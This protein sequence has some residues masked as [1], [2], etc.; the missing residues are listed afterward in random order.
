MVIEGR[1]S[2]LNAAFA[3][4]ADP[5]R[6]A[7]IARL[8]IGAADVSELMKPFQLSQ[9]AI[10]KHL[11]VLEK[12]GLVERGRDAQRRPRKLVAGPLK[13]VAAW[14]EPYRQFWQQRLASL[15]GFLKDQKR[16]ENQH[17]ASK[18]QGKRDHDK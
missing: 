18:G 9:P 13:D 17:S 11:S 4:L 15:D 16:K 2:R 8:A 7:I 6:R 5:T 3:A 12:A 1:D 14:V 10:S